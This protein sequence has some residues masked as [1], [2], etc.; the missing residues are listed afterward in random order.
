MPLP[1]HSHLAECS[2][3]QEP[4][5]TVRDFAAAVHGTGAMYDFLFCHEVHGIDFTLDS[6]YARNRMHSLGRMLGC[7]GSTLTVLITTMP[8]PRA[9]SGTWLP[10]PCARPAV[11]QLMLA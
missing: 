5:P 8:Q 10:R 2:A 11:R 7:C 6:S 3:S 1:W 9:I 4:P